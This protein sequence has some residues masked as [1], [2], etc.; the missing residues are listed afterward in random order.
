MRSI[1]RVFRCIPVY[2]PFSDIRKY[3]QN[4][5]KINIIA[6][7]VLL[8]FPTRVDYILSIFFKSMV[9]QSET[10]IKCIIRNI[11]LH[12]SHVSW[13]SQYLWVSRK[14]LRVITSPDTR[15]LSTVNS[16]N[17]TTNMDLLLK[18][19]KLLSDAGF[20]NDNIMH[21]HVHVWSSCSIGM[22]FTGYQND[23]FIPSC[24]MNSK[25]WPTKC[26]AYDLLIFYQYRA[27]TFDPRHQ[28]WAPVD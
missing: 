7:K 8:F 28:G 4:M 9:S 27:I 23:Y 20:S 19:Q 14:C 3:I 6:I 16:F 22:Y 13:M 1:L 5:S 2:V 25:I 21:Q 18:L 11:S 15:K 10:Q 24:L 17:L 12:L 26:K